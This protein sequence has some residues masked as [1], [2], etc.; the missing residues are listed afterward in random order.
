MLEGLSKAAENLTILLKDVLGIYIDPAK[1]KRM[2]KVEMQIEKERLFHDYDLKKKDLT[3]RAKLRLFKTELRRQYNLEKIGEET[4]KILPESASPNKINIDW[5]HHF[6]TCAQDVGED[7]LRKI[8]ARILSEEATNPGK[9]SK[10]TLEY[11]KNFT[12]KD[13]ELFEKLLPFLFTDESENKY[14]LFRSKSSP[15][16]FNEFAESSFIEEKYGFSYLDYIHLKNIGIITSENTALNIDYP[17]DEE[18]ITYFDTELTIQNPQRGKID[19]NS[20]FLLT[21]VGCQL[22]DVIK[23]EKNEQYLAE[24][25]ESLESLGLEVNIN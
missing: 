18:K 25:I 19:I 5:L 11:L 13:C 2:A 15:T 16:R 3:E 17:E 21:E 20:L 1:E 6:G 24:S 23:T 9:I 10:R 12:A 22:A 14:F 8:W 7:D 4:I